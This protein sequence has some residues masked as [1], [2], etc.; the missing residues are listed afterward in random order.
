[1]A[2]SEL[3]E[4]FEEIAQGTIEEAEGLDCELIDLAA[5]LRLMIKVLTARLSD[6]QSEIRSRVA[7]ADANVEAD[8]DDD[9]R[10]E[11][12]S[13]DDVVSEEDE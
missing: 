9:L 4:Q 6:V 12:E 13:D 2:K 11:D 7:S 10:I 1:M 8:D 5:G 3:A